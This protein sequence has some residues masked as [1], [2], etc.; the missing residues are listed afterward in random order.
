MV[1]NQVR[2]QTTLNP[3]IRQRKHSGDPTVRK[4]L[5]MARGLDNVVKGPLC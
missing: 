5:G 1:S 4:L 3:K 2:N